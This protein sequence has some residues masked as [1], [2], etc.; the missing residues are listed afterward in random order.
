MAKI[1]PATYEKTVTPR[2]P[3]ELTEDSPFVKELRPYVEKGIDTAFAVETTKKE[4]AA[5]K[6]NI[7]AAVNYLGF[8]AREVEKID[9]DTLKS[10]EDDADVTLTFVVRP[11]RKP[12]GEGASA[13]EVADEA[14]SE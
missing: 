1:K 2:A 12:R 14:E 10:L 9:A 4:S 5:D 3:R 8:T 7:Q 11:K 6:A 13:A